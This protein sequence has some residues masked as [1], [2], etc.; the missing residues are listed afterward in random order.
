MIEPMIVYK[1]SEKA[2]QLWSSWFDQSLA[3]LGACF[4]CDVI[5]ALAGKRGRV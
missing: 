2:A 3:A 1:I 5:P 4:T